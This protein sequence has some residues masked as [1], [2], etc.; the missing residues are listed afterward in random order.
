MEIVVRSTLAG[1]VMIA[2]SC[3]LIFN[4]GYAILVGCLA[5]IASSLGQMR[6][7]EFMVKNVKIH[8]TCGIQFSHG[9][10]GMLGAVTTAVCAGVAV[11][12]F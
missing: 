6:L 1:G 4:G 11:Y 3:N 5:G 7:D 9:I 12:N 2:G 10:P 8:D